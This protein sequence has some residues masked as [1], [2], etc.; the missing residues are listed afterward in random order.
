MQGLNFTLALSLSVAGRRGCAVRHQI[1]QYKVSASGGGLSI[2]IGLAE[3]PG[4]ENFRS[5]DVPHAIV[6]GR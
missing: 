2:A 1:F 5:R 6:S 4:N 3:V